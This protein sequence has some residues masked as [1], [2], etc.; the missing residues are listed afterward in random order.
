MD[1]DAPGLHAMA[2]ASLFQHFPLE[3]S[4][5]QKN[6]P[7][8][9]ELRAK[10]YIDRTGKVA[11]RNFA[12]IY[13]G[14]YDSA[15]WLYQ[16]APRIWDDPNRGK[17]P[18]GWAFNPALAQRFPVGLANCRATATAND[19]FIAG[20]SGF[21]YLNPGYLTPPRR[22]S[23]LPSGLDAWERL[24]AKGYRQWDLRVTGFVI[25]G[26]APPMS[27]AV[28]AAYG[29]FSTAGVV[30]Q[31][32]PK[33]LLVHGVPFLR[34]AADLPDPQQ[35]AR[36]VAAAFSS[37]RKQPD[38]RIFR[39]ILWTPTMHKEMFDAVSRQRPD[40][41]FVEPHML[42]ELLRLRLLEERRGAG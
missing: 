7:C 27:E 33:Q 13:V 31:K 30:A 25:D 37:G 19:T 6:L 4:Y 35:G 20:D 42:M 21:G 32:I 9:S 3:A 5:P 38:F 16:T 40:I 29:R 22:W 34:M 17:I 41:V 14:D 8:E 26:N 23:G 39:T 2:N 36:N 18:L 1:A 15:A 12:S 28:S 10:G 11:V 24:C